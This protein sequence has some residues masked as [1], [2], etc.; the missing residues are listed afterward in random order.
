[1]LKELKSKKVDAKNTKKPFEFKI[2]FKGVPYTFGI[3][4]IHAAKFQ[5][6]ILRQK[7]IRF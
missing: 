4:G 2:K 7:H 1:M 3:G 5:E 6:S